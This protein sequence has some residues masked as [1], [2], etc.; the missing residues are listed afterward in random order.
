MHR[1]GSAAEEGK[2]P[3]L[4][5]QGLGG[6]EKPADE[7]ITQSCAGNVNIWGVRQRCPVGVFPVSNC[8]AFLE[9]CKQLC[10]PGM[11]NLPNFSVLQGQYLEDGYQKTQQGIN[12]HPEVSLISLLTGW[13]N[14]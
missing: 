1:I 7:D 5:V 6:P 14:V 12:L 11:G 13:K 8:V 2:W 4:E 9:G 10:C 3:V